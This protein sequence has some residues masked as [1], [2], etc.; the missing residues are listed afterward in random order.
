[1]CQPMKLLSLF[2]CF[3]IHMTVFL[4]LWCGRMQCSIS[5][6]CSKKW[7]S[8]N[9]KEVM[10]LDSRKEVELIAIAA[11]HWNTQRTLVKTY[12]RYIDKR[13]YYAFFFLW[14]VLLTSSSAIYFCCCRFS[15]NILSSLGEM[16]SG[17]LVLCDQNEQDIFLRT[18]LVRIF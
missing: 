8:S 11:N 7:S 18:S 16:E 6:C 9:V 3:H 2:V 12:L 10:W 14:F 13:I 1:M 15:L 5:E 4:S 17:R